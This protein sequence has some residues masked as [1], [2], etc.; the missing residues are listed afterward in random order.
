MGGRIPKPQSTTPKEHASTI[1][2]VP[3]AVMAK[4]RACSLVLLNK[5]P[6]L[7][8][9]DGISS[10][11]SEMPV[12]Q[13]VGQCRQCMIGV[14]RQTG[15]EMLSQGAHFLG[16]QLSLSSPNRWMEAAME[17]NIDSIKSV[18]AGSSVVLKLLLGGQGWGSNPL[19]SIPCQSSGPYCGGCSAFPIR[20][21]ATGLLH[22]RCQAFVKRFLAQAH[23]VLLPAFQPLL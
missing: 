6:I 10:L 16:F 12:A 17:S 14:L 19:L 18:Q 1:C 8:W 9:K 2:T 13:L 5:S 20:Y 23:R 3:V 22:H 15:W 11:R 4:I 7:I 21:R